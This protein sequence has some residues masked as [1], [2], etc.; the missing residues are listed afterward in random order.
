VGQPFV[1]AVPPV[2][3][4]TAQ[5]AGGTT[6]Q[7]YSGS[8]FRLTNTSLTGRAY[9][10]STGPA[11]ILAGLPS[12][13]SD[14]TIASLGTGQGTLSFGA[15]TGISYTRGPASAPFTAAISLSINVID[16]DGVSAAN[17]VTFG[18]G[19]GIAFSTG[20]SQYYGRL[21]VGNAVGSELLDLPMPLLAEYYVGPAVGFATNGSDTC[22]SAPTLAFSNYQLNLRAG[23]TCVRDSGSPG[24]SGQGCTA[25]ATSRYAAAPV[26]GKYNLILAAP[27][28]GNAGS[29]DVSVNAPAWLQYVWNAASGQPSDPVGIASFGVFPGAAA[30]IYQREVY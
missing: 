16:L 19:S 14:P 18:A 15:G 9:A 21:H 13:A 24:T 27:G 23:E 29:L 25:P 8:L 20:A 5:A 12:V 10:S 28:S 2:I 17:P 30:R 1:Y 6:T 11:L 22:T 26:A 3:T 7:N 4:V